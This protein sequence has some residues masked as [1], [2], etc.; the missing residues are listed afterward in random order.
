M[1]YPFELMT[2]QYTPDYLFTVPSYWTLISVYVSKLVESTFPPVFW[3]TQGIIAF[4]MLIHTQPAI[5][6]NACANCN[7]AWRI[8]KAQ[9]RVVKCF[10]LVLF[11]L[12]TF[13]YFFFFFVNQRL[14]LRQT[15]FFSVCVMA[16]GECRCVLFCLKENLFFCWLIL[17]SLFNFIHL[18]ELYKSRFY[19]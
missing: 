19:M 3:T 9:L 4:C 1:P 5:Q 16:D 2:W 15:F 6:M 13:M 11:C 17:L 10:G 8:F 12:L 7:Q 14:N 18:Q